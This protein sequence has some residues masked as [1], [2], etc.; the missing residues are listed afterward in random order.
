[1]CLLFLFGTDK[2]GND[3]FS[4]NLYASRISL[5]IGLVGVALGFILGCILGGI[6]GYYGGSADTII[7]RVIEFLISIPT[8]PLWMALSAALPANWSPIKVY[9]GIGLD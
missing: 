7:Q 6:S 1:M 4:R 9:F 2:L 3:L 8:I 5:S